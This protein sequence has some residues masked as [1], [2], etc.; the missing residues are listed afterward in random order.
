MS[1]RVQQKAVLFSGLAYIAI[2]IAHIPDQ[3]FPHGFD[4]N[5]PVQLLSLLILASCYLIYI[6]LKSEKFRFH[7]LAVYGAVALV[8]TQLASVLSSGN[9]LGSLIG[10]S[11]RFVGSLSVFALL[12]VSIF[13][14]QFTFQPFVQLIRFYIVAIGLVAVIGIAQHFN[15][16]ELPGAEGVSSTLGNTDFFAAMLGT[17]FPLIFFL[18]LNSSRKARIALAISAA[19]NISALYF[20]GPLQGYLDLA[21][22]AVGIA[23]Y[24][25]RKYIPRREWT[26]NARTFLGTFAIII[27]AEF[28]FLMPF[29]GDFIPVLGNDVQVKIRSNFWL[30]G[31]RQFFD[32]ILFGVGPDQYGNNYEQYRT[33]ED[34]VKYTNIL[35]NDAHSASVQS[36]ATVGILG[37]IAFLFLLA[38]VIRSFLILWDSKNFDRKSLFALGLF[39]FIYLTNSFVSPITLTHK[40]IFWAVCGFIVGQVYRLPA[41]RSERKVSQKVL[42]V[43]ALALFALMATLFAQAQLNYLTHIERYAADNSLVQEY[44]ASPLLPCFMYFDAEL[45]MAKNQ[46]TDQAFALAD[47]ELANHPRCVAATIHKIEKMV[48]EGKVE[49]LAPLV[50]RLYEIAPAR[51]DTISLGMHYANRTGDVMLRQALEKEMK[52]LGLVY[53]PGQLG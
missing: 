4:K 35:S 19:I 43:S 40:F 11:G 12:V 3:I 9:L 50:Y 8:L 45:L 44:E 16:L 27:W 48:N 10:D 29:L 26:L 1:L 21:F 47:E 25:L 20:A 51:N 33:L 30:A 39:F 36:L 41:R 23:F 38:L 15:V 32:H 13:H 6:A 49:E 37:T 14:S 42:P 2:A 46:G 5:A 52:A 34:I 18:A 17:T 22:M 7:R 31:T 28:I 53:I 24:L